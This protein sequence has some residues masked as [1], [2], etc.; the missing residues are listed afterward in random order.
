M[1]VIQGVAGTSAG[2]SARWLR[3]PLANARLAVPDGVRE[4]DQAPRPARASAPDA[5]LAKNESLPVS[6]PAGESGASLASIRTG[7]SFLRMFMI[8]SS[9]LP[10]QARRAGGGHRLLGQSVDL[11]VMVLPGGTPVAVGGVARTHALDENGARRTMQELAYVSTLRRLTTG[12]AGIA[13]GAAAGGSA[14]PLIER[15][16]DSVLDVRM[17][18]EDRRTLLSA[19]PTPPAGLVG[20]LTPGA[21]SAMA[22]EMGR[23]AGALGNLSAS[24]GALAR[25][26]A[27]YAVQASSSSALHVAAEAGPGAVPGVHEVEVLRVARGHRVRSEE[28]PE[29]ALGL[30][31]GFTLNGVEIEVDAADSLVSLAARINAGEDLDGDGQLDAGEDADGNLRLDGGTAGHGVQASYYQG[32]LTL[33]RVDSMAGNIEAQDPDGILQAVG[34]MELDDRGQLVF[35]NELAAPQDAAIAVDGREFR[36]WDNVFSDAIPG[37]TLTVAAAPAHPVTVAVERAVDGAIDAV[38]AALDDF[39]AAIRAMNATLGSAGGLLSRDSAVARVRQD[40]VRALIAPVPGQAADLDEATEAGVRRAGRSRA[41]FSQAQLAAVAADERS[42][43]ASGDALRSAEDPPSVWNALDELGITAADDDTFA[44]D[45]ERFATVLDDRP[46]EVAGLFARAGEGIAARVLDR[47]EA[48]MGPS[49]LLT[50]RRAVLADL[51]Q[52]DLGEALAA[53]L[54]PEPRLALLESFPKA[55]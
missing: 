52:S 28:M 39:N 51:A 27:L 8:E 9:H 42:G 34:L 46:G 16:G 32:R 1:G 49:G 53:V 40:L 19:V 24:F 54:A 3:A 44:L 11:A 18:L 6:K 7:D 29:S 45:R 23:I 41:V 10:A 37:V 13:L 38:G 36:S 22:G 33:T 15:N 48:A 55:G 26:G 30:S 5:A 2:H 17:V 47:V 25:G 31:G 43:M 21:L 14:M 50:I 4:P 20:S 35:R 12:A